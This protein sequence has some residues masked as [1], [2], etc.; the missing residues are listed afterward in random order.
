MSFHPWLSKTLF[1]TR[2]NPLP[3]INSIIQCHRN[4]GKWAILARWQCQLREKSRWEQLTQRITASSCLLPNLSP[5][6]PPKRTTEK[7]TAANAQQDEPAQHQAGG[8]QIH[9]FQL[10]H[11][12]REELRLPESPFCSQTQRDPSRKGWEQPQGSVRL[13]AVTSSPLGLQ[14]RCRQANILLH[15]NTLPHL[16][17]NP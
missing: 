12:C 3:G 8:K 4:Q 2:S 7:Q 13:T 9:R 5:E 15:G 1:R 11:S 6:K 17:S 14:G 10:L 16:T